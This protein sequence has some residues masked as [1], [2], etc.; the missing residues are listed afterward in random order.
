MSDITPVTGAEEERGATN[1]PAPLAVSTPPPFPTA[2]T[3][4]DALVWATNWLST[5]GNESPRLDAE[6]LLR[7]LLDWDRTQ[8]FVHLIDPL[9][10]E[11][12][13][14]YQALI[15][16]RVAGAPVAY[17][18]GEREFM[19][20]PLLVGPGVLVPRPETEDLVEWLVARIQA[21]PRW[22]GRAQIVDV[23]TGS[24]AIA[25]SLASLLPAA[26]VVGVELS[27]QALGYA[28]Q[29]RAYL[30]LAA[31][32]GL[33]RGNLLG[34]IGAVDVIAA[35]LP[36]LRLNQLHAGIAQE[37]PEAL[38]AGEDGLGLYRA[39]LPQAVPLLRSPGLLA[40]EIDP[41]QSAAMTEICRAAFP[42]AVIAVHR[43]LAGHDRFVSVS[44]P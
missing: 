10:L 28:R 31:R 30:G 13:Q 40:A 20:L 9:P 1:A 7:H 4:R 17:L 44:K 34:P 16:R 24:G 8:L 3:V 29:N 43:D 27:A 37:P 42:D 38:F 2:A 15:A 22:Q 6:V 41:E 33:V 12:A 5:N 35:N 36:Y 25:L 11:L 32:V 39:L 19:G 18:V 21:E 23:G 26:R 14:P